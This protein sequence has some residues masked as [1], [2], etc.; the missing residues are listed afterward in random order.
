M[1]QQGPV[2][3]VHMSITQAPRQIQGKLVVNILQVM[4]EGFAW[5]S[6]LSKLIMALLMSGM[7]ELQGR[8]Y[9]ASWSLT[10]A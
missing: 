10:S 8:K 6:R 3:A 7:G 5:Q 1:S 4:A 2:A 9:R